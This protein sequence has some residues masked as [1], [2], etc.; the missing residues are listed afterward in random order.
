MPFTPLLT[1]NRWSNNKMNM[2]KMNT[3]N[4]R[5]WACYW[6]THLLRFYSISLSVWFYILF[7]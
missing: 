1:F 6:Q 7:N 4:K 2:N 5:K 3:M